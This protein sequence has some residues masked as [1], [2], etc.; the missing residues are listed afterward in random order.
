MPSP[1]RG[2]VAKI[3]VPRG[4]DGR[5]RHQARRDRARRRGRSRR[6]RP[7]PPPEPATQEAADEADGRSSGAPATPRGRSRRRLP[8]LLLPRRRPRPQPAAVRRATARQAFVSP[9]VARIAAEHGVDVGAS[10]G[11]RPGRP[12]DEEGH[13]RVHRVRCCRPPAARRP[14]APQPSRQPPPA[15]L[16]RTAPGAALRLQSRSA[17]TGGPVAPLH[18]LLLSQQAQPV[19]RRDRLEPMSAMRK[20]IAEHMRRSLDT[21]AHVTSAIEVDMSKV[22]AIREKLKKELESDV[23]REPD[24]PGLRRAGRPSRRSATTRGSTASSAATR[25]S[26]ATTSTSASRSS[27]PRAR[28]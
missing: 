1:G 9:V 14:A 18:P 15:P 17:R 12:R 24:L 5:R 13:P 7:T 16:R 19:A 27:S 21:S 6:H 11:H 2:V 4:R 3:L 8:L 20:G 22:V 26:R 23:R 25:S 10:P 28:G